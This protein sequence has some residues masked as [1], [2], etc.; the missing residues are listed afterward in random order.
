MD[1]S[2]FKLERWHSFRLIGALG[3]LPLVIPMIWLE[4]T[5]DPMKGSAGWPFEAN[6]ALVPF[7]LG[8]VIVLVMYGWLLARSGVRRSVFLL[9]G[10]VNGSVVSGYYLVV[11]D[12]GGEI[13]NR[14][15]QMT[16]AG[17][18]T[19]LICSQLIY[20]VVE[21]DRARRH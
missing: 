9:P 17:L 14:L 19:G 1:T 15:S 10:L 20:A 13:Y 18:V 2:G 21:N 6:S 12:P 4:G 5:S 3:W 8:T 7:C 16:V 11:A